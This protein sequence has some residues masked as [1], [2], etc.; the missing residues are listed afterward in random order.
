MSTIRSQDFQEQPSPSNADILQVHNNPVQQ[1]EAEYLSRVESHHGGRARGPSVISRMSTTS[2]TETHR[3]RRRFSRSNTVKHASSRPTWKPGA[4]PG[5]D[6]DKVDEE[7]APHL[8]SLHDKCDIVIVDYSNEHIVSV[9][10]SN[11]NLHEVLSASRPHNMPCRWIS[12]NGLSWDVIK[13]LGNHYNLHRLAIEDLINVRTR[14]KVDW[15]SDHAFIVL[16]LQKLVQLHTHPDSPDE[17]CDCSEGMHTTVDDIKG[18]LPEPDRPSRWKMPFMKERKGSVL[19]V[20]D[21]ESKGSSLDQ[22]ERPLRP[23]RTLHRYESNLNPEHTAFMEQN[24]ALS[25]EGQ[26]VAVE[27]V[28]IFLMANNT[29]ISFFE[30]SASDVEEP[31][32]ERLR[33][34]ATMLRRS[35]DAS[36]IMQAIIDAIVDLAIPVKEAYN[37]ARKELQID[38]L[39]NP[40]MKVSKALHI[41]TEE[42]DM[43]QNLFKPIV[44]LVNSLRDHNSQPFIGPASK[45]L[46]VGASQTSR[47]SSGNGGGSLRPRALKRNETSTSVE[48]TPIAHVYLGD[49]LDHCLTIIQSLEQM[50]A[51]ANN[52]S[53]LMFNTISANT[54]NFMMIIA[55]VTVF[56]SPLTFIT[57]YFGMNFSRQDATQLHSDAFFWYVA[58]PTTIVFI[59]LVGGQVIYRAVSS[60]FA[61][62]HVRKVRRRGRARRASNRH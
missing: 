7:V 37:T 21:N 39:N 29:C 58:V 8:E 48:I 13:S 60:F 2:S 35:E 53:N 44:N 46:S 4:E 41:F 31:I 9:E 62:L 30:N 17:Q 59:V 50:D 1:R 40:S 47:P 19:P 15:Y 10:A 32:L 33:S 61:R 23:I 26:V 42:I 28:A 14:T 54:N 6:I 27:Q 5:I 49:V 34:Q 55:L 3:A 12:V 52:L 16:S 22:D 51:S 43:I 25:S 57:G 18:R 45:L 20:F 11:D 36:L 24:S 38:V 56:F